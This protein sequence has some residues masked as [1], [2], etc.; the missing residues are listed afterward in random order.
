MD[1]K[2]GY[3]PD[4]SLDQIEEV[5]RQ[6][7]CDPEFQ[8]QVLGIMQ[9]LRKNRPEFW[10]SY[11]FH[12]RF[13]FILHFGSTHRQ[14]EALSDVKLIVTAQTISIQLNLQLSRISRVI[15]LESVSPDQ[16]VDILL[17]QITA[18]DLI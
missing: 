18:P 13:G 7:Q 17:S 12:S 9:L 16:C 1:L 3:N 8:S 6:T 2:P 10:P 14:S 5:L 11:L 4:P 15:D